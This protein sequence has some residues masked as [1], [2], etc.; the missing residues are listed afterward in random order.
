MGLESIHPAS[1]WL[2]HILEVGAHEWTTARRHRDGWLAKPYW[3]QGHEAIRNP[4]E[5]RH[6]HYWPAIV[7]VTSLALGMLTYIMSISGMGANISLMF[8]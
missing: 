8:Q 3:R 2:D 7:V 1:G 6:R 5:S 4:Y